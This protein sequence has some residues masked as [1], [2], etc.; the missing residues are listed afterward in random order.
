MAHPDGIAGNG[1]ECLQCML[2]TCAKYLAG[3]ASCGNGLV[4]KANSYALLPYLQCKVSVEPLL[5]G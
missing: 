4:R 3:Y 1:Y 2:G 5:N